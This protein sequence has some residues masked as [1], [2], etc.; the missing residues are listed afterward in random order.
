MNS[1]LMRGRQ[2]VR[3]SKEH[4]HIQAQLI[5]AFGFAIDSESAEAAVFDRHQNVGTRP[6]NKVHE[7]TAVPPDSWIVIGLHGDGKPPQ[8]SRANIIE[9]EGSVPLQLLCLS[10]L[11][12]GPTSR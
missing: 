3:S 12:L 4:S 5:G 1:G 2:A 6:I 10:K 11:D 9:A 7:R 8:I